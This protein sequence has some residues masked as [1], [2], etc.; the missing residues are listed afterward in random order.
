MNWNRNLFNY[1]VW[2]VDGLGL[3][4]VWCTNK[5]KSNRPALMSISCLGSTWHS[6]SVFHHFCVLGIY[7][8]VIICACLFERKLVTLFKSLH[9]F[10]V[11]QHG[12]VWFSAVSWCHHLETLHTSRP[13]PHDSTPDFVPSLPFSTSLSL[14][15]LLLSHC[16]IFT[17]YISPL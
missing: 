9:L 8:F 2:C 3:L 16:V 10:F 15:Y 5:K 1:G 14:N 11:A 13:K 4:R 12:R 7:Y 17:M 6:S